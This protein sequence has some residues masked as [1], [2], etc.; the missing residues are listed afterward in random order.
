MGKSTEELQE[1]K[2][3]IEEVNRELGELSK[4]ELDMVSGGL[5]M[6]PYKGRISD[7]VL[8]EVS[9]GRVMVKSEHLNKLSEEY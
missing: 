1:L 8:S 5:R 7:D 3:R 4:E 6:I 9:G 2:Q